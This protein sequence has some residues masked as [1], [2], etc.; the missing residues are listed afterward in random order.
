MLN[1]NKQK[2]VVYLLDNGDMEI[3]YNILINDLRSTNVVRK[4][5]FLLIRVVNRRKNIYSF[6]NRD[7]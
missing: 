5:R 6:G 1:L 7:L 3:E 2:P 4:K